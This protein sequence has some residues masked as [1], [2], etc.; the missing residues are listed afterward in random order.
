MT[1]I[2]NPLRI[3]VGFL[4]NQSIGTSRDIHFD[5]NN[6]R[7]SADFTPTTLK[8]VIRLGK[9]PQGVIAEGNFDAEMQANCVRCLNDYSQLLH[10]SFSELYSFKT[11]PTAEPGF[12][13]PDDS[14]IDFAPTVREYLVLE[15]PIKLLCRADCKGLCVECGENLNEGTCAHLKMIQV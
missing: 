8:G 1:N 10:A 13:I 11:H 2:R 6:Y 7:F 15:I 14:N 4:L 9:T 12:I 5:L 3:N